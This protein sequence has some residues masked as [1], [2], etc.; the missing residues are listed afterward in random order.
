M[1]GKRIILACGL[2]IC[3]AGISCGRTRIPVPPELKL[4]FEKIRTPNA[5]PAEYGEL[6]GVV[7]DKPHHAKLFFEKEDKS[8][9]VVTVNVEEGS[10]SD[11][12]L[13]I[14]RK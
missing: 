13:V 10:L 9:V 12:V 2:L 14:P 8:I 6:E 3:I 7:H 5:I 4:S 11:Q 1:N